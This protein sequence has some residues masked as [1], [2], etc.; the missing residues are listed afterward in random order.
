MDEELARKMEEEERARFNAEQEARALQEEEKERLNLEAAWELQRQLDERQQ[1]PTKATQSKGID[2]NDPSVLR[3]HALKNKPVS[4]AQARRN[5]IT[6]LKNQGGYKES[7]FKRMSYNDIRPIFERVWD[8]VN[9]FI[10]IGSEVEKGS[11][12][13]SKRE[14]LKTVVERKKNE[15][16]ALT[17][18]RRLRWGYSVLKDEEEYVTLEFLSVRYPIV[19][20][21]NQLHSR[22]EMKDMEAYK[23]TRADET[24]SFHGGVH[25]VFL[26]NTPM[27]INMLVEKKYPLK[28]EILEK[29]INLKLQAEEES[30]MAFELIKFIR[31][32]IKEK[33]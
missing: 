31:S 32:Q 18:K 4:I 15:S 12:K 14:T 5:M 20:W 26:T 27:E 10:P 8:H 3:Y 7:Y 6:Y 28:K 19:N 9:T 11:S 16:D 22:I 21:E 29:M 30:T 2:W 1:V 24:I 13:P 23:L 17:K 33:Q 25:S